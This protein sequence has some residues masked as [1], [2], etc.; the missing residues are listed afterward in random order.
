MLT[1][2]LLK[3]VCLV[4]TSAVAFAGP[5]DKSKI[6]SDARWLVH[7][8]LERLRSSSLGG[9]LLQDLVQP[10]V[11]DAEQLRDANLS[12]NLTNISAITAYGPS[13][14]KSSEGVLLISTTANVKKDLDSVAGM[15]LLNAGTNAPFIMLETSPLPL[16][17]FAKSIYFAPGPNTLYV[18]KSREQI[19]R[20]HEI[21]QGKSTSLAKQSSFKEFKT[22]PHAFLTVA[23]AEGFTGNAGLP[24][25]AQVLKEAVGGRICI[26]ERAENVFLNLT[27]QGRDELATTRIQQVL[28]GIVALVS[29]AQN[30]RQIT[31]LAGATRISSEG[32]SVLV[33][34]EYPVDKTVALIKEKHR[35][36]AG[37]RGGKSKIDDREDSPPVTDDQTDAE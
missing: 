15:F 11:E 10:M 32:Q 34:L 9:F 7:I 25:Q 26:G 2:T 12:I 27:F 22:E 19:E 33:H 36:K 5:I 20:A 29:L 35:A 6:S 18:A 30:D 31:Q 4:A 3:S 16:Y 28:Q 21:A 14:D 1:P 23:V 37:K 8:D 17:T 13:F 24:V